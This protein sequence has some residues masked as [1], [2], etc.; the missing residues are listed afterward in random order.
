[1]EEEKTMTQWYVKELSKLTAISVQTLH[2]YDR[3]GLLEP[4]VRLANGYRLYSEK[5]LLKLQ[6]IIALKFFGFELSR[7]KVLLGTE[8][9]MID[10]FSVQ[11]QFLEEKA[12]S[13][14][15]AS[16]TLKNIVKNCSSGKSISW[17]TIMQLI[18]VYRMT[19]QLEKTWAGK[20]FTA[21][22]LK[23]YANFL[24]EVNSKY[25]ESERNSI[26]QEWKDIV[27]KVNANLNKN[28]GSDFGMA[29][30]KRLLEWVN[31][32]YGKQYVKLRNVIWEQGLKKGKIDHEDA[33]SPESF[34][35]LDQ[36]MEAYV[37]LQTHKILSQ[38]ATHPTIAIKQWEEWLIDLFGEEQ[39]LKHEYIKDIL[40]D[41]KINPATKNWLK[42]SSGL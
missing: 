22:E 2:H 8:I 38:V 5:D 17:E 27:S 19:Q 10:H 35:W 11:S 25:T 33:L 42:Q 28:P 30:G 13:L 40:K 24:Q 26:T 34:A 18:E 21:E 15:E 36:A 7:I 6:Q 41:E 23:V 9:D 16:Q 39:S 32:F 4:S 37:G 3:I 14:F 29:M 31:T 20:I 12:R 1:M